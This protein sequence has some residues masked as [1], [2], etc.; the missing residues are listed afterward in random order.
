MPHI[1]VVGSLNMD[2]VVETPTIP[3]AG[4]TVLGKNFATFPGGKGAN[5]AVAA[6]RLGAQVSLIGRVGKDAF[7][8]QLLASAQA[9]GIDITHVGR[10]E[11]AATGVA[12]IAVDEQGQNSIAVASGANFCLTADHVRE[13]WAELDDVDLLVMP[14]ETPLDTIETAVSLANESG[15]TV[16]LNPAPA[17]PLPAE[18]LAGIDVLVPNEPETAQ[19][20]ALP[21]NTEAESRDA[22]RELLALGVGNVVLTLGSRGALVLDGKTESF[23]LVPARRVE[24]VD[25]T[26]AGDAFVAGL[27][28]ALGEGQTLVEAAQFANAVGALAVTK[29]GAQPGMPA[30]EEVE[31]SL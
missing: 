8:D 25:T 15:A 11:T 16:V 3:L 9:D 13:A 12:M 4:E 1:V 10:D 14:L 31:I 27:A 30:R 18:L 26:A 6:A 7:G 5:Q 21:I 2:L 20:T 24:V 23:T 17:R 22:A 28:V 29:Q 19:L